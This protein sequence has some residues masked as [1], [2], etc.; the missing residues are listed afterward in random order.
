MLERW[1]LAHPHSV[2]ESYLGHL[3]AASGFAVLLFLA[4]AACLI[5]ALMPALFERTAS[6]IVTRLNDRM[7]TRGRRPSAADAESSAPA[8]PSALLRHDA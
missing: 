3:R 4:S 1:F 7:F 2:G 6:K 5:H 8:Y